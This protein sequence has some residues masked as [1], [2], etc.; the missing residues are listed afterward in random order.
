MWEAQELH[1]GKDLSVQC[2]RRGR[3][4]E[5]EEGAQALLP[6]RSRPAGALRLKGACWAETF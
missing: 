4:R 2:E 3:K 1:E 5:E 6:E